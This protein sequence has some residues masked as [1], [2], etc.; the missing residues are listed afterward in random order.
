[1]NVGC[2]ATHLS[3][4]VGTMSLIKEDNAYMNT[5]GQVT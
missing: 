1:M 4:L 5:R 2:V 3:R